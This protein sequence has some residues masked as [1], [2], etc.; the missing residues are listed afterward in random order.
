MRS[1]KMLTIL[2][3]LRI[4]QP[5]FMSLIINYAIQIWPIKHCYIIH[6]WT[7]KMLDKYIIRFKTNIQ[8]QPHQ[9]IQKNYVGV[10]NNQQ[11]EGL[12]SDYVNIYVKCNGTEADASAYVL[13]VV[14]LF[15]LNRW[16]TGAFYTNTPTHMCTHTY[17]SLPIYTQ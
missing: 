13:N 2:S 5:T 11:S 3:V 9:I 8:D 15:N 14:V 1:I 12:N 16:L 7:C 6:E 17:I 4:R 10:Y